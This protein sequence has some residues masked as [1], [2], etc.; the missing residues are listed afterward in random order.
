MA[1]VGRSLT[2]SDASSGKTRAAAT[3]LFVDSSVKVIAVVPLT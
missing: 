3:K 2:W 1:V